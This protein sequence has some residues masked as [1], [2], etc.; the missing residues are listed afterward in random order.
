M[1]DTQNDTTIYNQFEVA[2]NSDFYESNNLKY[3]KERKKLF[4]NKFIKISPLIL[5]LILFILFLIAIILYL[6][7][8]K[9]KKELESK[10]M[11]HIFFPYHS[12]LINNL[13]ILKQLK[14]WIKNAIFEKT[15]QEFKPSLR[16]YYK[17]TRDGDAAFHEKTDNWE[18]YIL[19]IQDENDNIFGGYTSKNFKG[20]NVVGVDYGVE[21]I[22]TTAFL[23][24]LKRN[25][26]YPLI[27][28][29]SKCHIYGDLD[30]GPVFGGAQDG[31]LSVTYNFLSAKSF[32]FFP[33]KY[34]LNGESNTSKN[35]LRLTN[36]QSSFLIKELEVFRVNLLS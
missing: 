21:K 2:S 25:E 15:G 26:I 13:K 28:I 24:N 18:G 33:Q 10:V 30:D 27:D 14:T 1:T 12:D 7:E 22:D 31:D 20:N 6:K 3:K 23:F 17:A 8:K 29:N 11:D 19:L 35:Q 9:E 16:M 34:N 5:S 4:K 36:G 32:S